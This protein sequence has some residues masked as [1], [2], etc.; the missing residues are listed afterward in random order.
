[1]SRDILT[2]GLRNLGNLRERYL[3]PCLD[4]GWIEMTIPEKPASVNQRFRLT[5]AGRDHLE[6]LGLKTAGS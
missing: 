1:M 5:S 6:E 2:A 3:K 4:E